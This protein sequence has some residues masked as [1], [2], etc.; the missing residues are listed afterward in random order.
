MPFFALQLRCPQLVALW[1]PHL[2]DYRS[3]ELGD[4]GFI[5]P[6]GGFYSIFS[7]IK[8]E[9]MQNDPPPSNFVPFVDPPLDKLVFERDYHISRNAG[10]QPSECVK[11]CLAGLEIKLNPRDVKHEK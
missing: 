4:V 2:S 3:A 10:I 7:L 6:N 5:T 11:S 1:T 8:K 9:A